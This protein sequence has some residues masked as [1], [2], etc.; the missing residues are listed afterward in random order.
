MLG[1]VSKFTGLFLVVL[2]LVSCG[3]KPTYP[4]ADNHNVP[5]E[6]GRPPAYVQK[7]WDARYSYDA[8]RR[9]LVPQY[10]GS[11]W[12]RCNNTK[13]KANLFTRTGG[14]EMCGLKT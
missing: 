9:L 6:T 2:V 11:R 4:A 7:A 13:K 3:T 14:L 5:A 8:D 10:A 1:N 12:G